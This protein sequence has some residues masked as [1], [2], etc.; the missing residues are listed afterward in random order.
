MQPMYTKNAVGACYKA[1]SFVDVDER[2]ATANEFVPLFVGLFNDISIY[3]WDL[4]TRARSIRPENGN[5]GSCSFATR[6]GRG[7]S[8]CTPTHTH[9]Q[10]SL[11][12]TLPCHFPKPEI[13]HVVRQNRQKLIEPIWRCSQ[14][15]NQ[16]VDLADGVELVK[17]FVEFDILSFIITVV[18]VVSY[19][20]DVS[21]QKKHSFLIHAAS[22]FRV[23]QAVFFC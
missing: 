7:V 14:Q 10:P 1:D 21:S 17:T 13:S 23:F 2:C 9:T 20:Q 11:P 5:V 15:E 12:K 6:H 18:F 3:I 16:C 22:L 4:K 19:S 8:R